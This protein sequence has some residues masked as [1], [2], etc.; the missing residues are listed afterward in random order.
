M[1]KA[2][3]L[4]SKTAGLEARITDDQQQLVETIRGISRGLEQAS[5]GEGRPVREFLE[6]LASDHGISLK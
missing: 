6:E 3:R 1:R 2:T 5:R 4:T